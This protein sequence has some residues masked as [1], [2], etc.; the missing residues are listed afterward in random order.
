MYGGRRGHCRHEPFLNLGIVRTVSRHCFT[1]IDVGRWLDSRNARVT[2]KNASSR[3]MHRN[4]VF[5]VYFIFPYA[6]APPVRMRRVARCACA[7]RVL[8]PF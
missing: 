6:R 1:E 7:V 5:R 2:G 4:A 3:D 8:V